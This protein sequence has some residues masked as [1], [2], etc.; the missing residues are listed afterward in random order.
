VR[1]SAKIATLETIA[2]CCSIRPFGAANRGLGIRGRRGFGAEG[3]EHLAPQIL[4]SDTQVV[5]TKTPGIRLSRVEHIGDKKGGSAP[6]V[7]LQNLS[8][9]PY[10]PA[11]K[12]KY[13][14]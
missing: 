7:G 10:A 8:P 1:P 5:V 9:N 2:N 3:K 13:A 11:M 6:L 4:F 12:R 14:S